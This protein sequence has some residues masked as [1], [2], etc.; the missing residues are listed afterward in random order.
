ML[1]NASASTLRTMHPVVKPNVKTHLTH[2]DGLRGIAALYVVA[3][4]AFTQGFSHDSYGGLTP[5]SRLVTSWLQ[6]GHLSVS[7]FIVLSGYCLMLPLCR[8]P[9]SFNISEFFYR[10]A[11]RIIPPYYASIALTVV[12]TLACPAL[13][14]SASYEWQLT[15]PCFTW[16]SILSHLFLIQDLSPAWNFKISYPLWSVA[17]EWQIYFVFALFLIPLWRKVGILPVL[18]AT[19]VA[20]F[21]LN[22]LHV[23]DM[24]C[25]YLFLFALGM[26]ASLVGH[27]STPRQYD[28]WRK[29][30]WAPLGLL[31]IAVF[32]VQSHGAA[33]W[34]IRHTMQG[35]ILIGLGVTA[36]LVQWDKWIS[37]GQKAAGEGR[38]SPI[39]LTILQSR[40]TVGLGVFSYSLYVIHAPIIG[41]VGAITQSLGLSLLPE[42]CLNIAIGVPASVAAAYL[43]FLAFERPF[44]VRRKRETFQ[45][46]ANDA[47]FS[48]AP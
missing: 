36:A 38:R 21:I 1:T 35:D 15:Q 14:H 11:K 20:G 47:V 44:L 9:E 18:L 31:S 10:R 23:A 7:I 40:A 41:L 37:N 3:Y 24:C 5:L 8:H 27:S 22:R 30:L 17:L 4:H 19:F 29:L 26:L 6:F 16:P 39:V 2:L 33:D 48:P 46:V 32:L 25:H 45:Q 42:I 34:L 12:L 28:S 13:R 43:F